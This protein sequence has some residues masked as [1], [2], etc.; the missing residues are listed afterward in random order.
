MCLIAKFFPFNA[1]KPSESVAFY[2]SCFHLSIFV[3][4]F[5]IKEDDYD[6]HDDGDDAAEDDDDVVV[7]GLSDAMW[8]HH[9]FHVVL[10]KCRCY[11]YKAEHFFL[12][13][14]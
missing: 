11:H 12:N 5:V 8:K 4:A 6:E 1:R 9:N 3:F 14:E 2:A 10:V 7:F 13:I